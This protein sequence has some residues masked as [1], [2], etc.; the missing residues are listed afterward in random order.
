M[1]AV[2]MKD[3]R[4]FELAGGV[5]TAP[6]AGAWSPHFDYDFDTEPFSKTDITAWHQY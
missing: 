3:T 5:F 2:P 6:I 4:N 1:E